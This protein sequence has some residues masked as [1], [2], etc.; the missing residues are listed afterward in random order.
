MSSVRLA[1]KLSTRASFLFNF[2]TYLPISLG[3]ALATEQ[4]SR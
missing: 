3:G 1:A 2:S 4:K